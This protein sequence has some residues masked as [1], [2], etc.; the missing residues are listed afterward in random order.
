MYEHFCVD[1]TNSKWQVAK[2]ETVRHVILWRFSFAEK[3]DSKSRYCWSNLY[4]LYQEPLDFNTSTRFQTEFVYLRWWIFATILPHKMDFK[5]SIVHP[6]IKKEALDP[7]ELSN[8][9]VHAYFQSFVPVKDN[10]RVVASQI[11]QSAYRKNHSS[12]T[13]LIRVVNDI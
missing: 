11:H 3:R 12:E 9:T 2:G 1:I 10:W 8:Y 6:L 13:A 5:K 7:D 4:S